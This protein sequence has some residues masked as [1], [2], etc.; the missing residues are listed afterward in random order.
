MFQLY[1]DWMRSLCHTVLSRMLT[2]AAFV[3]ACPDMLWRRLRYIV[4]RFWM[5]RQEYRE[6]RFPESNRRSVQ[7]LLLFF[8]ILPLCRTLLRE[9]LHCLPLNALDTRRPVKP[10]PAVFFATA[11]SISVCALLFSHY[12]LATTVSY[13]GEPLEALRS[14]AEARQVAARVENLT[15][16]VLGD[17]FTLEEDLIH[18]S[19]GLVRRSDLSDAETLERDLNEEIGLVTYGYTLCIDGE[20]VVATEHEGALEALL[21]QVK[22][23]HVSSDTVSVNFAED[24]RIE[25]GYVPTERIV[26][27]GY[28][29]ELIN[30]TKTGETTYTVVEGDTWGM[31]AA[32]NGMSNDELF[33][34]NPGYDVNHIH[35]GDVLVLS[36]E[37]PYLTVKLMERQKYTE[38]VDYDVV[39]QDDAS[40]YRGDTRVLVKGAYGKADVLALVEYVNGVETERTVISRI[41]LSEPTTETRARGTKERPSWLPTGSFR[42]PCYGR[43]TSYFGY[44]STGIRGASTYHKGIDIACAYGTAIVAA[45]GGTV[46]YA[47]YKGA[48]GYTVVINHG[49]GY[50]TSYEHCS[51]FACSAGQHVYKGQTIAYVGLSGVTSGAHCHFGVQRNGE[52]VNPM[53]YLA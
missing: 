27:L 7:F 31:I 53:K 8:G 34:L 25:A 20:P 46:E 48:M 35:I 42:W 14:G 15:A 16:E 1:R 3:G 6:G 12:T 45:D 51:S 37:V 28:I 44:R 18:Y 10:R 39:Y 11:L 52:Y 32:Q 17:N 41:T 47:G 9:S 5:I 22:A 40:M 36:R 13:Q 49:N 50:K 30:S 2:A 26:N 24:V 23:E 33:A 29:A 38:D 19:L 4:R 21:E 43:I